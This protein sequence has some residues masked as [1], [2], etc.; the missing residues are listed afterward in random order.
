[1]RVNLVTPRILIAR[2]DLNEVTGYG[3]AT[4]ANP[5]AS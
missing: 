4:N 2:N 1:M 3:N 5:A